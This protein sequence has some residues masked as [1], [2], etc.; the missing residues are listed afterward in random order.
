MCALTDLFQ[1]AGE[2]DEC[3]L[4][5]LLAKAD[6][7]SP[8]KDTPHCRLGADRR[9]QE[10][11]GPGLPPLSRQAGSFKPAAERF[12]CGVS[13]LLRTRAM[14]VV[15]RPFARPSHGLCV[16]GRA[17]FVVVIE[18]GGRQP[19]AACTHCN[20]HCRTILKKRSAVLSSVL[21][22]FPFRGRPLQ[23]SA[24]TQKLQ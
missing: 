7:F 18:D 12:V 5:F 11:P 10:Y 3:V 22:K 9:N 2:S 13:A 15:P 23:G 14:W 19:F 17:V 1:R 8:A 4:R 6:A 21:R 16:H 24:C 20:A